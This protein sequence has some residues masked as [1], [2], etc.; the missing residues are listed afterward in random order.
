MSVTA[1]LRIWLAGALAAF[2]AACAQAAD[3]K[4]YKDVYEKESKEI[5]QAFQPKFDGLQQQYQRS[6]D[7]LKTLVQNQGDLAKTKATVAEIDRFQ[8]AK[9]LPAALDESEI[10]EIKAFQSAYVQQYVKLETD[11]T[12]KLGML[13]EKYV[14]ALDRLLK[15][16]V[17]GE[18]LVEATGVQEE[19]DKVRTTL[20]GYADQVAAQTVTDATN[21]TVVVAARPS[22]P[23][24]GKLFKVR[25][26]SDIGTKLGSFKKGQTVVLQYVEGQWRMDKRSDSLPLLS[27]DNEGNIR[28]WYRCALCKRE[29][30]QCVKL[31][32]LPGGTKNTPF[33]YTLGEDCNLWLKCNDI[34]FADN[35]GTVTYSV[36][37][38][39]AAPPQPLGTGSSVRAGKMDE[40]KAVAVMQTKERVAITG[41]SDTLAT[42]KGPAAM[43]V[44]VVETSPKPAVPLRKS[45]ANKDLYVVI[46]LSGGPEAKE[47]PVT[48]LADLPEG[49]WTDEYK[50]DKLVLRKIQPGMFNMGCPE[51]ELG[52]RGKSTLHQVTLTKGFYFGVF[53]VTQ[54]QWERVM[55]N[56]PS[57]F[58]NSEYR[59]ARPV[60]K[61]S[62]DDIRGA[63]DGANWPSSDSVDAAS[64]MGRLRKRTGKALDLPTEAQ[65]EYACRAG[66]ATALNSGKNLTSAESCPNLAEVGR[67]KGNSGIANP[68]SDASVGTAKAGS[69]VSNAWGLYDLHG[70]VWEWC[71]D[72]WDNNPGSEGDSRGATTVSRRIAHS[73]CWDL[74]ASDCRSARRTS[75]LA[76]TLWRSIGFRVALPLGQP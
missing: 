22:S 37:V 34:Y 6:L 18:K 70:N 49:G 45:D 16:L 67:Y 66:T 12:S 58:N 44:A 41:Y 14:Q 13:T 74:G 15:E 46:D 59:D 35:K 5:L 76:N 7:A 19:R 54:K 25:S 52:H 47:Y 40:A 3:L 63:S 4:T 33:R 51:G 17:K 65:W 28:D 38:E 64:F 21:A 56:W 24:A 31:A 61:V 11:L 29:S 42:P 30:E 72:G 50:T 60:E 9:S 10:P 36:T 20:K 55:G 23:S 8:K 26:E 73:G 69:Y 43:N 57:H 27:P 75:Y 68:K 1:G 39:S 53:E 71:L 2:A 62:Y 48:F 32:V